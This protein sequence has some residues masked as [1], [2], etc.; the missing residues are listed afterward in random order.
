MIEFLRTLR[1]SI[2]KSKDEQGR[3]PAVAR[4]RIVAQLERVRAAGFSY[5]EIAGEV[6]VS[7]NTLMSW[8]YQDRHAASSRLQTVTVAIEERH[9]AFVVHGPRG[10]RIEGLCVDAIAELWERLS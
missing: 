3:V 8:R 6:G 7:A 5:K 10:M 9:G 1:E 2:D 4:R